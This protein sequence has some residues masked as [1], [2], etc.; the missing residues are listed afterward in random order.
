MK[1]WRISSPD[2]ISFWKNDVFLN[3]KNYFSK[4][5]DI[6]PKKPDITS[7][8]EMVYEIQVFLLQLNN[9]K[10]ISH[11]SEWSEQGNDFA[12]KLLKWRKELN[13]LRFLLENFPKKC[14][15]KFLKKA[16]PK[17]I[18]H[19]KNFFRK[20][21][22]PTNLSDKFAKKSDKVRKN[23]HFGSPGQQIQI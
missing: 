16:C 9:S 2:K 6:F 8:L 7:F 5:S 23:R 20:N 13:S 15:N 12:K 21:S 19:F 10:R 17:K 22:D 11:K 18:F 1:I 4:R 14:F 3:R